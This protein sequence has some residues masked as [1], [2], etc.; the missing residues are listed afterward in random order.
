MAWERGRSW[1]GN[2]AGCGLGM[3]PVVAW[4]RGRSWPGN[5]AGRGLGMRLV[6][7][8]ELAG[9]GL[10]TRPQPG[11]ERGRSWLKALLL[12]LECCGRSMMHVELHC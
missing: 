2:E 10:G 5:G 7:A 12:I 9:C 3:R 4:E 6:V 8:W 11:W 1:P